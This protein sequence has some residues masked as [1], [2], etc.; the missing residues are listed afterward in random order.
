MADRVTDLIQRWRALSTD[1]GQWLQHWDDLARV[2]LPRRLGFITETQDGERRVDEL[3]D[4]TPMQSARALAN[5]LGGMLRP[6]GEPWFFL[7]TGEDADEGTDEA[8]E[9][10]A[11]TEDRLR[12]GFDDPKARF[13]QATGEADLDLVVFGTAELWLGEMFGTD[14]LLFQS[15]HL[16][17]GVPIFSESGSVEGMF[18]S[19]K[20]T[21]RQ[22]IAR[23]GKER[24]SD[25]TQRKLTDADG[26][27]ALDEKV[28][29]LFVTVP[30]EEG[31]A[32]AFLARNLPFADIVIEVEAKHE[33]KVGGFHEFPYV[34]PRWDTSSGET[35]GRS[36]GMI[37]LPDSNTAQAIG[38]TMLIAGQRAADP[39][40]LAPSD[41][42]INAPHT[43]PGGLAIYE[44]DAVRELG[45]NPIRSLDGG[46]NFPLSRDIQQDT[47]EQVRNAFLRNVFNLPVPGDANMTATEVIARQQEFIREMGPVFGRFET[48]YTAPMVERAFKIMLRA[49]GF[50]QIPDVLAGR[51]VR[52][53]YESPV[54]RIRE[55]AASQAA[56]IWVQDKIAIASNTGDPS[57]LDVVNMDEYSKFTGQAANIP[58]ELSNSADEIGRRRQERAEAQQR[59]RQLAE[60]AQGAGVAKD[61]GAAL[62]STG[63]TI[64][65]LANAG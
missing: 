39:P 9:W 52:F 58:H 16:K 2:Q 19:R 34:V 38:E 55:Q 20:L 13:R 14:Q 42:F 10:L 23:F 22:A 43:Y 59:A 37:A 36:P 63:L 65:D 51:G 33:V 48:D 29:F 28:E 62:N 6:E 15:V 35:Y 8:K 57:V 60:L 31:R 46:A 56:Q 61:A 5:A 3:F 24:L 11:D 18:R 44:A 49:G 32:D 27:K 41:A 26:G 1:R 45:S 50:L 40:L 7:K 4:G 25:A 30:R 12:R 54:K 21:L 47:R 64:E 17:D 53:E